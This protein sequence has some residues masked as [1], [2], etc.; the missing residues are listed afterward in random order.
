MKQKHDW[1]YIILVCAISYS[2]YSVLSTPGNNWS[3]LLFIAVLFINAIMNYR[4]DRIED[5]VEKVLI[6]KTKGK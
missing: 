6:E 5:M 1:G 2:F 4:F 3:N